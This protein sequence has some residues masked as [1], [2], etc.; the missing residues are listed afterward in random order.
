MPVRSGYKQSAEHIKKRAESLRGF[1]HSEE[2]KKKWSKQRK[3]KKASALCVQKSR[4]RCLKTGKNHPAYKRGFYINKAGYRM[5]LVGRWQYRL[6]HRLV[7]EQVLGRKL[8]RKEVVHHI[9]GDK[10]NNRPENL[11]LFANHSEHMRHHHA[12]TRRKNV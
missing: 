1:R 2:T 10:L 4:E 7:M 8:K 9:D 6:E 12:E 3:G 5:V 11:Q